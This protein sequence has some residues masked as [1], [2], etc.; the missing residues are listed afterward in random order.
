MSMQHAQLRVTTFSTGGKLA[1]NFTALTQAAR[2][3]MFLLTGR[4]LNL[5]AD[6]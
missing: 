2:S 6:M 3:C 4:E 5:A 1:S